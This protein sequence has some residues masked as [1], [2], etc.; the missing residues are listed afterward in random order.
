MRDLVGVPFFFKIKRSRL[1]SGRLLQF[2]AA[3]TVRALASVAV[4][5]GIL[6][7]MTYATAEASPRAPRLS[8][9]PTGNA[10]NGRRLYV[11]YGCYE[12]HGFE[13]QGGGSAGPRLGP[14]S[15]RLRSRTGA[16][17]ATL[18]R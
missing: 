13:G 15:G 17:N 9:E 2:C 7:S 3:P 6:L 16:R 5:A 12:C 10:E 14:E 8:E 1:A 18:F 11:R 4:V